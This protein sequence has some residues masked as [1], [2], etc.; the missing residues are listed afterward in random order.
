MRTK[1]PR[2]NRSPEVPEQLRNS[3][4]SLL[5]DPR[6]E[7]SPVIVAKATLAEEPTRL[8]KAY[9]RLP[10][11]YVDAIMP[12]DYWRPTPR[13][14][15]GKETLPGRYRKTNGIASL[16]YFPRG[17]WPHC[18]SYWGIKSWWGKTYFGFLFLVVCVLFASF[19]TFLAVNSVLWR[20][21][22][23][24]P[25]SGLRLR[26]S[27]FGV[28]TNKSISLRDVNSFGFG[29]AT[30]S[31]TPVLRLEL[32]TPSARTKW[33]V[34]ASWT[35]QNEVSAFLQDIEAQGFQLPR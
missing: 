2:S 22:I 15:R 10:P 12:H 4:P 21:L 11:S 9:L 1:P 26:T 32:R 19:G 28:G 3:S 35:T 14:A 8:A 6:G 30:H 7:I 23:L 13:S 33:V 34:L 29:L 27:F 24:S 5:S 17:K 18:S 25:L 20:T 16:L 31:F